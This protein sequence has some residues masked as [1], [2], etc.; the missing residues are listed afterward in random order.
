MQELHDFLQVFIEVVPMTEGGKQDMT[1]MHAMAGYFCG[2]PG[3]TED[4]K[5]NLLTLRA[6][7]DKQ[8][9]KLVRYTSQPESNSGPDPGMNP[10]EGQNGKTTQ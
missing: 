4:V 7:A 9:I 8:G 3:C 2:C 1:I 6:T 10:T 5:R